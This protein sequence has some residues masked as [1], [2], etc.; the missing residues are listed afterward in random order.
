MKLIQPFCR[1]R[2][3]AD[4]IAFI[5]SVLGRKTGNSDCLVRL[6]SDE[7]SRDQILDDPELLKALLERGGCLKVSTRLYFYL[8]VRHTL[9]RAGINDRVVADYLA[10]MMSDFARTDRSHCVLPGQSTAL[11][12]FFEMLDALRQADDHTAFS[13]RLHVG[14]YALFLSGVF[15]ERIQSRAQMRGFPGL[16]YYRQMGQT[17]YRLASDHR[18]ARRYDLVEVLGTLSERFET[19][20]VAL[21]DI[22][23]RLLSLGDNS[24]SRELERLLKSALHKQDRN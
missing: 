8:L 16:S 9:V 17:Q 6:L 24:N 13:V 2:F 20:R 15:P 7:Q 21:N 11:D 5:V 19:A 22:A 4:D 10:E 3:D 1:S 18:L 14:N 23:D 12:Y